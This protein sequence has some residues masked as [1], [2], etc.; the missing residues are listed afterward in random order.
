MSSGCGIHVSRGRAACRSEQAE[1]G[2]AAGRAGEARLAL[3]KWGSEFK[4]SEEGPG[5]R[6]EEWARRSIPRTSICANASKQVRPSV[7]L[8]YL[9]R[10]HPN[11]KR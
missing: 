8:C 5:G 6:L 3:W 2:A 1:E 7:R 10:T 11:R 9:M 4:E